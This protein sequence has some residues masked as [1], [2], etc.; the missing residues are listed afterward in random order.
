MGDYLGRGCTVGQ[1]DVGEWLRKSGRPTD[2]PVTMR[3][4]SPPAPE[5]PVHTAASD[6]NHPPGGSVRY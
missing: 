4:A 6:E 1:A 2:G 3:L 5:Q